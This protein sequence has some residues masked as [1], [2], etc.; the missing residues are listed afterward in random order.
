LVKLAAAESAKSR[1]TFV[2]SA[3]LS[4]LAVWV[5]EPDMGDIEK[6][7]NRGGH[8]QPHRDLPICVNV[9]R[10]VATSLRFIKN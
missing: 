4:F 6:W 10:L 7:W 9:V 2:V 1:V 5:S 8:F 3:V